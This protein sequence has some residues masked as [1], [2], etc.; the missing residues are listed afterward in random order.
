MTSSL[1]PLQT[2]Y[3]L[4]QADAAFRM[5]GFVVLAVLMRPV[6]GW[7]SDKDRLALLAVTA[8]LAIVL[9]QTAVRALTSARGP[10]R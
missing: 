7:L 1:T 4:E 9:T 8:A 5:A 3:G 2:G 10:A 6:G